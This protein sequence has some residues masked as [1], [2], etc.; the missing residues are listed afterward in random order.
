VG[1]Q[2]GGEITIIDS[3]GLGGSAVLTDC[4]TLQDLDRNAPR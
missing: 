3:D 1:S 4:V 2:L